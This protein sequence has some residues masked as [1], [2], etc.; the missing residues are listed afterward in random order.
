MPENCSVT[1]R[2]RY[3]SLRIRTTEL[4]PLC[5]YLHLPVIDL[6]KA[7]HVKKDFQTLHSDLIVK[8]KT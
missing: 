1:Q 8:D 7:F 6:H 2:V 3:H 4:G 5:F